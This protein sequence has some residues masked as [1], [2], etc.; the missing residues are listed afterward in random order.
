MS[1]I[2]HHYCCP[3]PCCCTPTYTCD[4]CAAKGCEPCSTTAPPAEVSKGSWVLVADRNGSAKRLRR[5]PQSLLSSDA[6]G[7]IILRDGSLEDPIIMGYLQTLLDG[8][9]AIVR[10]GQ[11]VMGVATPTEDDQY[12]A[13]VGGVLQFV[14]TVPR[15]NTFNAEDFQPQFGKVATI[16]CEINGQMTLG[17]LDLED[18][19]YLYTVDGVIHGAKFCDAPVVA[20]ADGVFVCEKGVFSKLEGEK[21]DI[22][23]VN[24][25]KK[26]EFV[27]A[28]IGIDLLSAHYL[29][30]CKVLGTTLPA[31]QKPW[32]NAGTPTGTFDVT[33]AG[34]PATAGM[35][36]VVGTVIYSIESN[37]GAATAYVKANGLLICEEARS[38][39]GTD[40]G[41]DS[42]G[43]WVKVT[44]KTF[45]YELVVTV[46]S[47]VASA[48]AKLE[49]LGWV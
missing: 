44:N 4:S 35:V 2:P 47:S 34:V 5:K 37:P 21:G 26:A 28:S 40:A 29:V 38:N 20:I 6:S 27:S 11:G 12:F 42:V 31:S 39:F 30:A 13:Y 49:I 36:W 17:Y 7:N 16:G 18:S 3:P 23:K 45:T 9:G 24:A 32:V 19:E 25:D 10:N 33:T 48:G 1:S 41:S 43:T 22:L 8:K 14:S 15:S 46:S